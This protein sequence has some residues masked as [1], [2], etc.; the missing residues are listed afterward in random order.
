MLVITENTTFTRDVSGRY[1]CNTLQE[2]PDST[3]VG[4]KPL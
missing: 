2:A 3:T 1:T 4:G